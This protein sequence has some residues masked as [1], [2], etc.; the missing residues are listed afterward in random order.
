LLKK[1]AEDG[2]RSDNEP[3]EKAYQRARELLAMES[4]AEAEEKL[5]YIVS[6][7]PSAKAAREARRILGE[8]NVDRL[9]DPDFKEGKKTI[10]VKSG[11]NYTR[12]ISK[13][14]TTLDSVIHLSKLTKTENNRLRIGQK[15]TIMPLD[16]RLII[17]ARRNTLTIM[18]G[19][20][21]IKEYTVIKMLGEKR[22]G[23]KRLKLGKIRGSFRDK[24]YPS[25]SEYY[26]AASKVLF[27]ENSNLA[28]R[29]ANSD[30]EDSGLGFY[31]APSDMEELP[32][33]LRPGNEVE[34]RY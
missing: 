1:K 5:K 20:E 4:M 31:L 27:L 9:L 21:F 23:V 34:I 30:E 17:D 26:R 16:M 28:L 29:A 6:F 8:I 32:L 22:E 15:L 14:K 33:L 18:R 7:Y 25:H 2:V 3:G 19:G 24:M 10:T 12:I 11:D 13:N